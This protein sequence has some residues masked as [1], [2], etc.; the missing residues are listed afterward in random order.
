MKDFLWLLLFFS[1]K[2]SAQNQIANKQELPSI[3]EKTKDFKKYDGYLNF[4]W[5]ENEGKIWLEIDKLDSEI[6]YQTSLPAGLGSND[7]GL[8][9]GLLGNTTIVKFSKIGRKVLMIQPNYGYRAVTNDQA[10]Q[11]AVEESFAQSTLWG[12]TVSAQTGNRV[13]VEAT[14]F[15]IRDAI[16]VA[17]RIRIQKQG[18]Y[19]FDKLRKIFLLILRSKPPLL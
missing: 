17:N 15:I 4:Y 12:F 11:K 5:D 1:L 18:N 3:E 2:I 10:E 7:I 6:L 16:Q 14:D 19:S 8:D 13:L 9:R